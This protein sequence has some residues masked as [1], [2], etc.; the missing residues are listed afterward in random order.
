[1]KTYIISDKKSGDIIDII[2]IEDPEKYEKEN[3]EHSLEIASQETTFL[4]DE[5]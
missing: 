3:P 4:E 5:W 1:M 2:G